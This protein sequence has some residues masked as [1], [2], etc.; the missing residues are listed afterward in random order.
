MRSSSSRVVVGVALLALAVSVT[1][2]SG[3]DWR[4]VKLYGGR[5]S[6]GRRRLA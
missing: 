5:G 2:C 4:V 1:A 3:P 6:I